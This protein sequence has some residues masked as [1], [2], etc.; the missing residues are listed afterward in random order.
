MV[1]FTQIRKRNQQRAD[2]QLHTLCLGTDPICTQWPS[3][4]VAWCMR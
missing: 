2:R 3:F 1:S 4:L